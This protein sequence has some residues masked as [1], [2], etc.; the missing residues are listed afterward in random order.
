MLDPNCFFSVEPAAHELVRE[1]FDQVSAL[2]IV[3]PHGHVDPCL[4]NDPNA[5]FGSPA[6]LFIFQDQDVKRQLVSQGFS[7]ESLSSPVDGDHRPAWP[8]SVKTSIF[9]AAHPP[10]SGRDID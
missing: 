3:S 5:T 7:L 10:D 8:L 6:D 9:F 1:L 4:F 2:P